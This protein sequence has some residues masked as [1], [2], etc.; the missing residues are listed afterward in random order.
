MAF[1]RID[2]APGTLERIADPGPLRAAWRE[3]AL[4]SGSIFA[5]PDW[6]EAWLEHL[7]AR[8]PFRDPGSHEFELWA[9]RAD[10]GALAAVYPLVLVRGRHVS[11]LR[12]AGYG[13]APTLGPAPLGAGLDGLGA[14]LRERG[15]GWDVLLAERVMGVEALPGRALGVTVIGNPAVRTRGL[16]WDEYLVTRTAHFRQ[17]LRS[18][19]RRLER[20]GLTRWTATSEDRVERA[21]DAMFSLYRDRWSEQATAW[22]G[23]FEPFHR[24][25]AQRALAHGWLRLHVFELD[26]RPVVVYYAFRAAGTEWCYQLVR[27]PEVEGSPGVVAAAQGLRLAFEDGVERLDLGPYTSPFKMRFATDVLPLRTFCVPR[28]ARGVASWLAERRRPSD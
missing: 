6:I 10:D 7:P 18:R 8:E 14:V 9:R 28:T 20:R 5:T 26:G 23:D 12:F 15:R 13:A 25:F 19:E 16:T 1:P 21:L 3:L 22:I 24:A 11:K 4:A 27:D 2:R 17:E